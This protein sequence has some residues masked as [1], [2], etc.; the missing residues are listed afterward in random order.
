LRRAPDGELLQ[1]TSVGVVLVVA[2][3]LTLAVSGRGA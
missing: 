2:A 1:H 3:V